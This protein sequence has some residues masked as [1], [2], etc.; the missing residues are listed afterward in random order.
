MRRTLVVMC[1]C[2]V[3]ALMAPMAVAQERGPWWGGDDKTTTVVI[4]SGGSLSGV[5]T[6]TIPSNYRVAAIIMPAAWDAAVITLAV[7]TSATGTFVPLY[8]GGAEY[9]LTEA[10]AS[11]AINVDPLALYPWR[12]LKLRSGTAASAVNQTAE[13]TI[14]LVLR[15]Y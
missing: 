11:R 7:S 13:R 9:T 15:P 10:A 6:T 12:Y 8:E 14:T 4:A 2:A 1:V 5:P 3:V